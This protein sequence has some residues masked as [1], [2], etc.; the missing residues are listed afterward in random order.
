MEKDDLDRLT[1]KPRGANYHALSNGTAQASLRGREMRVL[2]VAPV[3][4]TYHPAYIIRGHRD[5]IPAWVETMQKAK[6][7]LM[8]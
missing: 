6:S 4:P 3:F 5:L 2:S 1:P 7:L 8:V